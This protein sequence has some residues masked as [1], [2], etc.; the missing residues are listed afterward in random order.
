MQI[1]NKNSIKISKP[2]TFAICPRLNKYIRTASGLQTNVAT[3]PL[4]FIQE[5]ITRLEKAIQRLDEAQCS[6]TKMEEEIRSLEPVLA[7]AQR[8]VKQ[9]QESV[10]AS[11]REYAAE[12]E[13]CKQQE[14]E[15]ERMQGPINILKKQA[16]A[17]FD[18]VGICQDVCKERA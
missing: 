10:E 12:K 11:Q 7:N 15:I 5:E 2:L 8:D 1:L 3:S 13:K 16:Q 18:R 4:T 9:W 6:I 14:L 17:E